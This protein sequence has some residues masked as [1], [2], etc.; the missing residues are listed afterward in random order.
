[1]AQSGPVE[2]E[3]EH[4]RVTL[5]TVLVM[6]QET[7]DARVMRL[8][9]Y[10][11]DQRRPPALTTLADELARVTSEDVRRQSQVWMDAQSVAVAA[12]GPLDDAD[13]ARMGI[14]T[15]ELPS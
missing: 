12:A 7:P 5:N 1:M 15:E 11:L 8:G 4:T 14:T 10:G 9:R 3:L 2:E 13:C 6:N